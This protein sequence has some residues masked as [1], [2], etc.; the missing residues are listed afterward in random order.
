MIHEPP[1]V[2]RGAPPDRPATQRLSSDGNTQ[3]PF[4]DW[5][6]PVCRLSFFPTTITLVERELSDT[7]LL[8]FKFH[9][10]RQQ[11]LN[12]RNALRQRQIRFVSLSFC[13]FGYDVCSQVPFCLS[14]SLCLSI[15]NMS[16]SSSSSKGG[17]RRSRAFAF[18]RDYFYAL[19]G[20]KPLG[21][22]SSATNLGTTTTA[23][24][25]IDPTSS[26]VP[27]VDT[28]GIA[29]Y[30]WDI[31][32]WATTQTT[33]MTSTTSNHSFPQEE[34][35]QQTVCT[36]QATIFLTNKGHVY[37]TGTLHGHVF[38]LPTRIPIPLPLA[39]VELSAGRHFCLGRMEGGVAV[40]S[41]GA[42]HFG[43]LGL[44]SNEGMA[45]DTTHITYAPQP[46]VIERLLPHVMGTTVKQIAAGDWHALALVESGRVWAWG[47]NR[48]FQCG[49]KPSLKASSSQAPTLTAPLPVPLDVDGPVTQIAAG[50]SHSVAI[51]NGQVY[52]WGASN[53]GQC[54]TVM[55]RSGVLPP[56]KIEGL[57]DLVVTQVAAAGNHTVLLTNGG[58]VF[59]WGGGTEG[60]LGLG[61]ATLCQVKP[62]MVSELD[63]VA[64]M[65][66]QEWKLQQKQLLQAATTSTAGATTTSPPTSKGTGP[67]V[68]SSVPKI[69]KIF[70][71]P[72]YSAAISSSGH[73][74]TWGSN[75]AGQMGIP[76]PRSLPLKD[77]SVA[78]PPKTSTCRDLHVCTFDSRHNV[79]LPVRVDL[80][81]DMYVNQVAC[82]PNHMWFIGNDRTD[83]QDRMS[84]G[85]TLYE[86][87]ED[88]RLNKMH[89]ARD[90]LLSKLHA[91]AE[92]GATEGTT[93]QT[94]N[95]DPPE[96]EMQ[97]PTAY[98][99]DTLPTTPSTTAFT[100]SRNPL[101]RLGTPSTLEPLTPTSVAFSEST[102]LAATPS[103][104][105][106]PRSGRRRRFSLPRMFRR[107]SMGSRGGSGTPDMRA[108]DNENVTS[109]PATTGRQRRR[110]RN[111][112]M[113]M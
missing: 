94:D 10:Y 6:S 78:V 89:R 101:G 37:Q 110:N 97:S 91:Q 15:T 104:M 28:S 69:T 53:H 44:A 113:S 4:T 92:E 45:S 14:L 74:Y 31:P 93:T 71:G 39:C 27:S 24:S 77:N 103:D 11:E 36:T 68:L 42:G 67:H 5:V 100:T 73:V 64:I 75:D 21:S 12:R 60:E 43:Q 34:E 107:L 85:R 40:V 80:A 83:E 95:E 84:V 96:V 17:L 18:G 7:V 109:P 87:Q 86:V 57:S 106:S 52:C 35:I 2:W 22:R 23:S 102:S 38:P 72:S 70:A 55:R 90:S 50:R 13:L 112:R 98:I 108:L 111:K 81:H 48:S 19:G 1:A 3:T 33:T 79:L 41:W 54:G 58:R 26:V 8:F 99:A 105:T 61:H 46:T 20:T 62:K 82:G 29:V 63:F 51:A 25:K 66:G 47:S 56:R 30:E 59:C 76:T 32:P 9:G 88:Q 49:R 16:S 65:A